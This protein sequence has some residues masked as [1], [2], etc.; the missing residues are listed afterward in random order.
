MSTSVVARG[1]IVMAQM[2][3]RLIPEGWAIDANGHP[4][5]D[6]A[7][8][9]QGAV[10]P[11]AGYKGSGLAL[12]IDVLCGVL[13]GSSFATHVVD[14]YDKGGK[15]QD[16]GHFFLA[17][18]VDAFMPLQV[19]KDRLNQFTTEL[20]AQPR[21][22][23]VERIYLP[24]ELEFESARRAAEQGVALGEGGWDELNKLAR[25]WNVTP[26]EERMRL[27]PTE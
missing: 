7:D 24:G 15:V 8:A 3:G 27:A 13:T 9:L 26:L 17:V 6:P 4:T 18:A 5:V 11:M 20:R 19:F 2:E 21:M 22:P 1:K 25:Q 16:V 12:M 23:G 10:L 14:L